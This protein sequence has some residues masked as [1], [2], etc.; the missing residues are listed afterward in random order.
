MYTRPAGL[1]I[2]WLIYGQICCTI[3]IYKAHKT[4][5]KIIKTHTCRAYTLTRWGTRIQVHTCKIC[6]FIHFVWQLLSSKRITTMM[7]M[8][9]SDQ[10]THNHNITTLSTHV[11]NGFHVNLGKIYHEDARNTVETVW[12][13][14]VFSTFIWERITGQFSQCE[15]HIIIRHR[16]VPIFLCV[17]LVFEVSTHDINLAMLPSARHLN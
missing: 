3:S 13:Y 11:W 16:W 10:N 8:R 15:R 5:C 17:V 6:L 7:E 12:R 2:S 4:R 14:E 9:Y 1:C